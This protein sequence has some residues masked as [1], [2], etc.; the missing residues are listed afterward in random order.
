MRFSYRIVEIDNIPF[1]IKKNLGA[2]LMDEYAIIGDLH[3]GFEEELNMK[4]YNVHSK[5]EEL[6]KEILSL[7]SK[8]LIMLG[9]IR[10]G[11][12]EI[13]PREG[14]ILFTVLARLSSKFEE[15]IITKGNHDGGLFKLTNRLENVKLLNEFVYK[16]LGFLHGHTLPSKDVASKVKTLCF[17]HLHPSVTTV[18]NNGVVYKKDCWS[19]FDIKLPKTRYK[20][21]EVRYGIAFPKFNRY[22]GSTDVIRKNG[23]MRYAKLTRRLSTDL[24]IV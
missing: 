6:T 12:T 10:S 19:L 23:L 11:Y 21:S 24:I 7:G 1:K 8:K 22:I 15:I 20:E 17:G 13:S 9:D 3:L 2:G 5:T 4:G 14:G 16:D 18:D